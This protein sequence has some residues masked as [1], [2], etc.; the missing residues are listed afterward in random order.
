M[1]E[2][3]LKSLN[4]DELDVKTYVFLLENG[5]VAAGSLSKQ[6]GQ[7]RSSIYGFLAR[8]KDRG[9]IIESQRRG[10]K[11]FSAENPEKLGLLFTQQ[12]ENLHKQYTEFKTLLPTLKRG[13]SKLVQPKFQIYEGREG[14]QSALKDMLLYYDIETQAF[15]PQKK[16]VDT[17]TPDFFRYHNRER[18]K[19][20]L[21]TRAIW[22]AEQVVSIKEHPYFGTGPDFKRQIR[23]AP[24]QVNF[25]LGYWIYGNKVVF[26]SSTKES[27]GFIVESLEFAQMMKS[28]FE[29]VWNLS[30][31]MDVNKN[32]AA[33]FLRELRSY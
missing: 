19:N 29:L 21:R 17:L 9:L 25:S 24:P 28:Q 31:E 3:I 1:I 7:P 8:L 30:K 16:M 5:P 32:D 20:N 11:V 33:P 14:L 15:W 18:I 22:P 26:I 12:I 6:L 23:I 27:F 13:G 4:F 2:T 10:I